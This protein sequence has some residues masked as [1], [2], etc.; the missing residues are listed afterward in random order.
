MSTRLILLLSLVAC[1]DPTAEDEVPQDSGQSSAEGPEGRWRFDRVEDRDGTVF[2][3][4]EDPG[5]AGDAVFTWT[6]DDAGDLAIRFLALDQYVPADEPDTPTFPT[7]VEGDSWLLDTGDTLVF[8]STLDGDSWSLEVDDTH[9]EN[10]ATD[11]PALMV[12]TRIPEPA[13]LMVG[14]WDLGSM[15][16]GS[17]TMAGGACVQDGNEYIRFTMSFEV[18][19]TFMFTQSTVDERYSDSECTQLISS[20]SS[21]STGMIEEAGTEVTLYFS[22]SEGDGPPAMQVVFDI[23]EDTDLTLTRTACFPTTECAEGVPDTMVL[24][25]G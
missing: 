6:S 2:T 11:G 21:T 18:D 1:G 24:T 22:P 3:R 5:I 16:Q 15:T 20:S 14:T 8:T 7:R 25:P 17:D 10:E 19:S 13:G 23:S 4:G 12:M 9:P